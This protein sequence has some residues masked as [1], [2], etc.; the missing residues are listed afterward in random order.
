MEGNCECYFIT[1]T[2]SNE[3]G[4]QCDAQSI[5]NFECG[6][7]ECALSAPTGLDMTHVN[8]THDQFYWNP[9][10][11]A[12]SYV[13]VLTLGDPACC[14][15]QGGPAQQAPPVVTFPV[16]Y[17]FEVVDLSQLPWQLIVD[18]EPYCYSWY[19]YA[20]CAN[21]TTSMASE[22]KCS[23]ANGGG[24]IP[25]ERPGSSDTGQPERSGATHTTGFNAT[26]AENR[27]LH[28]EHGH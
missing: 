27:I 22:V 19:V 23:S 12:V 16:S 5:C 8:A 3:C 21:G 7:M 9:V 2:S 6:E 1:H 24:G 11:G 14:G 15:T 17:N 28:S 10:P 26:G 20:V 18:G 4:E 25:D 13:L